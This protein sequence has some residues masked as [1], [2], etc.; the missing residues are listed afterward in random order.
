MM[1]DGTREA[2]QKGASA[3]NFTR[4]VEISKAM[5]AVVAAFPTRE[6]HFRPTQFCTGC[7]DAAVRHGASRG[8]PLVP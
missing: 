4:F 7:A 8:K 3:R 1:G 6:S 2:V 5:P